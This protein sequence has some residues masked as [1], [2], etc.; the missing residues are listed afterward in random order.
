MV[1]LN[2]H[3]FSDGA[4]PIIELCSYV[5]A[6]IHVFCGSDV[7]RNAEPFVFATCT[8]MAILNVLFSVC[9]RC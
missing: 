6:L 7:G 2:L 4:G 3:S 8:E 9:D 5:H 1:E